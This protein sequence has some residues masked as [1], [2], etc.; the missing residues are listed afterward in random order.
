M[1]DISLTAAMRSNLLSLQSTSKLLDLTQGRL[2]TG[3]KVNGPLDNP[4]NYFA[5]SNMRLRAGD[6]TGLKDSMGNA[7][8]TIKAAS[9]AIKGIES[10]LSTAKGLIE[11]ARTSVAADRKDLAKQYEKVLVQINRLVEDSD[12]Q[13]TSF[14]ASASGSLIALDVTFDNRAGH[15]SASKLTVN[16]FNAYWSVLTSVG[17]SSAGTTWTANSGANLTSV[18]NSAANSITNA[19]AYLE[20]NSAKLAANLAVI[21]ARLEF[22]DSMVD[23]LKE[24]SD[25]LTLADMNEES[26]NMLALQTRQNL[27]ITSLSLA[28]QA[29]QSILR[30]F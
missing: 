25:K 21:S 14:L 29:N 15:S 8:Q 5:A 27:G 10:L 3:L 6:L 26:A 11:T 1:A 7:I 12:F 17:V 19:V 28:S 9:N 16:G 20:K 18:L 23:T 13:G 4:A 2:S 22:T 24:G 30:L